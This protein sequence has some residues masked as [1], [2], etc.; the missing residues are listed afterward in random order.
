MKTRTLLVAA[1]M[2]L[3]FTAAA[4]A[5]STLTVGSIPV[6]AVIRSGN[7][8]KTGDVTFSVVSGV[9]NTGTITIS[10]GVP[11]TSPSANITVV[12][13]PAG[14]ATLN[15]V[16]YSGGTVV[17]N[18]AAGLVQGNTIVLSG[19]RVAVAGTS[20]TTLDA[21]VSAVANAITAGQTTVRVIN[22]IA[23][24]L[25][26]I[27]YASGTSAGQINA[28][29][30]NVD[31]QSDTVRITEN[32]LNAFGT[33]VDATQTQ[34][35]LIRL[36]L[37]QLPP[38]YVTITFPG[39]VNATS[40]TSAW[41]T[42]S[43]DSPYTISGANVDVTSDSTSLA[44]Y[45]RLATGSDPTVAERMGL[46]PT[47]AVN[48]SKASFPLPTTSFTLTAT[49]YPIASAFNS[50]GSLTNLPIPRYVAEEVGPLTFLNIVGS[51]TAMIFPYMTASK[52]T[53]YDTGI[54]IANTTTDPGSSALG[55]SGATKQGGTIKFWFYPQVPAGSST[56]PTAISYTT[57]A[58]SPGTGLDATGSLPSGSTYTVLASQLLKDA[59]ITADFT[60]YMIAVCNF[61]NG[62]AQYFVSN[63]T[64]F[65]QGGQALILTVGRKTT[66]EALNN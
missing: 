2:L 47:V 59:G 64:T 43:G 31:K 58:G 1:A 34:P 63:F 22:S 60:G 12:S 37:N 6:T 10:Y 50:D 61:S 20:L 8:E 29:S 27:G 15:S 62:H 25:A 65:S 39:S 5:Q 24:G 52:V 26:S 17:L 13:N 57:K 42:C 16:S 7:A 32:F 51:S 56:V 54:A 9:S 35:P 33:V 18:V 21:S 28:V 4:Y 55:V 19:V 49:F 66:P 11:I 53:G 38:P 36:T 46:L 48:T 40:G 23:A 45:Y 44:V 30:G 14:Q 41:Q 3:T